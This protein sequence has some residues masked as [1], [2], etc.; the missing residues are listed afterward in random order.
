[1]PPAVRT[2]GRIE[3]DRR[4][5]AAVTADFGGVVERLYVNATG[6]PVDRGQPLLEVSSP[7]FIATQGEYAAAALAMANGDTRVDRQEAA[8]SSLKRLREWNVPAEQLE[9]LARTGEVR[10]T[11]VLRSPVTGVVTARNAVP[12][13]RFRPGAPLVQVTDLGSVRVVAELP[14]PDVAGIRVG[15]RATV[16]TDAYP[17]KAFSGTVT[18]VD[19]TPK[20]QTRTVSVRMELANQAGLLKPG[21]TAQVELPAADAASLRRGPA[22][23]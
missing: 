19:A 6:R 17:D 3:T 7:E 12:G 9:A 13:T 1:M 20:A 8:A 21:M 4:L 23:S 5:V 14:G 2:S 18:G 22:R 10:R 11:M 15:A 16:R